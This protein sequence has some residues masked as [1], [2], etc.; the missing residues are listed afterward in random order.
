MDN[1]GIL[2]FIGENPNPI[3]GNHYSDLYKTLAKS[4]SKLPTYSKANDIIN[5]IKNNQITV[6]IAGTG[7]GK[8]VLTPK[9]AL[10][11]LDYQGKIAVTLPKRELAYQQADFASKTLDVNLGTDIGYQYKG[12]PSNANKDSTKIVYMTDGTLLVK[13]SHDP[14]LNEY[15]VVIIDEAHE[16]K[17]QIDFLMLLLKQLL[18]SGKRPDFKL[19]IMSATIDPKIFTN[20]FTKSTINII[21]ISGQPNYPVESIFYYKDTSKYMEEIPIVIENILLKDKDKND[22]LVFVSMVRECT[23]LREMIQ[24]KYKDVLALEYYSGVSDEYKKLVM[25]KNNKRKIIFTTNVAESSLT[26]DGLKYVIDNGKEFYSS[27][28][29]NK[30]ATILDTR[31]ISKAQVKQRKGRVGRTS[32]GVCYHLYTEEKFNTFPNYPKP[33]IKE[34]DIFMDIIKIIV[35]PSVRTLTKLKEITDQLIDPPTSTNLKMFKDVMEEHKLI[36]SNGTIT[37][38]GT[39]ISSMTS[40]TL[41]LVLFMF[42]AFKKHVLREATIIVGMMEELQFKL[43]G[44]YKDRKKIKLDKKY[45]SNHGDHI[46]LLH[47]FQNYIDNK[48]NFCLKNGLRVD[49]FKRAERTSN[50]YY[51]K[52]LDM[53]K[54]KPE[55]FYPEKNMDINKDEILLEILKKTHRHQT[56]VNM[57]TIYPPEPSFVSLDRY[58]FLDMK[59]IK[60]NKKTLIYNELTSV[61]NKMKISFVSI[62]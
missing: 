22:I 21:E 35:V 57:E 14:E 43:E 8:T 47:L 53:L 2:D 62:V 29:N 20:Y 7:S 23:M 48:E 34:E 32:P 60:V 58:C 10:H 44:I 30:M 6:I 19:V 36:D 18:E 38:F 12:S 15:N 41:A 39:M 24:E 59:K 61:S 17:T 51:Y 13:Q 11:A 54:G 55:E 56:V 16:R 52:I 5:S 3:T 25:D 46:T 31:N 37:E 42:Y 26:I 1:K 9:F 33:S 50:T 49:V 27:Y 4:W 28:D 40:L 45:M